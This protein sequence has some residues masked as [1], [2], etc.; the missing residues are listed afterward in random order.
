MKIENANMFLSSARTLKERDEERESLRV[1]IGSPKDEVSE[2]KISISKKAK[3]LMANVE[4]EKTDC[5]IGAKDMLKALLV[6][7]LTGREVRILDASVFQKGQDP[8]DESVDQTPSDDESQEES[9]GWGIAYDYN[10]SHYEKEE[11]YFVAAGIVK[12]SDG[13]ELDFSLRLDMSREFI[14]QNN[15]RFRAGDAVLTDPLVMN[16]SGGAAELSNM[17]FSFDLDV[18]GIEENLPMIGPGS[19]LLAFDSNL[20]GIINNG[21]E[22]FGP[23][24]GNGFT[25][26]SA[27]DSDGN[28]WID[29]NDFIYDQLSVW[30]MGNQG[31]DLSSLKDKGIGAIYLG[32][33]SSQFDLKGTDNELMGQIS[34]TGLFLSEDGIAGTIQQLDLVI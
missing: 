15:I 6:E 30:T 8:V 13:A 20:D 19:G 12:T 22:L 29:E 24:T 34:R 33:V 1:W 7:V 10:R 16:F 23:K 26:L 32:N 5:S 21:S 11:V 3:C 18:D 4:D 27:H 25:E 14:S 2:D 31:S 28:Q 17:T 9:E